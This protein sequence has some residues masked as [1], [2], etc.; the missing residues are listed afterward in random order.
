MPVKDSSFARKGDRDDDARITA[1]YDNADSLFVEM[2]ALDQAVHQKY[3]ET[4][5][6]PASHLVS[7]QEFKKMMFDLDHNA[8]PHRRFYMKL[9][10]LTTEE[11]ER[12]QSSAEYK[13]DSIKFQ[14]RKSSATLETHPSKRIPPSA[15]PATGANGGSGPTKLGTQ[16]RGTLLQEGNG[17][18][19]HA[20]TLSA[21]EKQATR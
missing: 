21:S 10:T 8:P 9:A 11:L 17:P 16:E 5:E 3:L 2:A 15:R 13:R 18:T 7:L 4:G 12:Y 6:L 14:P 1:L 20:L 19:S